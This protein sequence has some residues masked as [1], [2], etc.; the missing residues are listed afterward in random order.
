[1]SRLIWRYDCRLQEECQPCYDA[2]DDE[3]GYSGFCVFA[4]KVLTL[5][6]G[7]VERTNDRDYEVEERCAPLILTM[8]SVVVG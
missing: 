6:E 4:V 5:D 3:D 7:H 2:G 8:T 1:M